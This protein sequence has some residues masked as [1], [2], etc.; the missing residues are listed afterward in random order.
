M[1]TKKLD[2]SEWAHRVMRATTEPIPPLPDGTI[3]NMLDSGLRGKA[4]E[5]HIKWLRSQPEWNPA[6][7]I[8]LD[9]SDVPPALAGQVRFRKLKNTPD[10]Q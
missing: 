9:E 2:E 4:K 3:L 7:L 6:C 8:L 10:A 1:K 5:D